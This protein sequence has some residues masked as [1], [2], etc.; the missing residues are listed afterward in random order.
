M[1]Y[2]NENDQLETALK[3]L[4]KELKDIQNQI[5]EKAILSTKQEGTLY[6]YLSRLSSEYSM[7]HL[8]MLVKIIMM[9]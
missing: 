7:T 9:K 4:R 8:S 2:V 6:N 3:I 5:N 1:T